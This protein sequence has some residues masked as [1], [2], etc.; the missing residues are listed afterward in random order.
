M[1]YSAFIIVSEVC[2]L[3]NSFT[4]QNLVCTFFLRFTK[5]KHI[6]RV[7]KDL[8]YHSYMF[9][10]SCCTKVVCSTHWT[11]KG[12][13]VKK[14]RTSCSTSSTNQ[15]HSVDTETYVDMCLVGRYRGRW[16]FC[17]GTI[18]ERLKIRKSVKT[19]GDRVLV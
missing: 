19:R 3:E 16:N 7:C 4:N 2:F 15:S 18:E 14:R 11:S 1:F 5:H 13:A 9:T 8:R 12:F 6:L 17:V 10:W